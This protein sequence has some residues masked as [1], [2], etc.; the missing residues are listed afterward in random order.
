MPYV[1]QY[2]EYVVKLRNTERSRYYLNQDYMLTYEMQNKWYEPYLT[3]DTDIY[4]C[5][6]NKNGEFVGTTRTYDIDLN[7]KTVKKAV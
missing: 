4:W 6:F 5:I 1:P 2:P 3:K 7:G